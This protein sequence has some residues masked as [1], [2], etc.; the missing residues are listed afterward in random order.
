MQISNLKQLSKL[1]FAIGLNDFA[2]DRCELNLLTEIDFNYVLL[3]STFSK[4]VLQQQ[5]YDLQ[6]QGV[7]AITKIKQVKVIAKGPSILNFRAL[8]DTHGLSLFVGKQHAMTI[9]A[10]SSLTPNDS[11]EQQSN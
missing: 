8:L 2:K 7:L 11:A 1:G 10:A 4:R 3:S 9:P 6:L 5:S